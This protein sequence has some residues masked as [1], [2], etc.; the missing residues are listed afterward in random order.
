MPCA[1]STS[2]DHAVSHV[3][4]QVIGS[5]FGACIGI[6]INI[7]GRAAAGQVPVNR[8]QRHGSE[9]LQRQDMTVICFKH[10]I[11]RFRHGACIPL[12]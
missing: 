3:L 2:C 5:V 10:D 4:Q 1:A 8:M 6:Q 12:A 9:H 7:S 11:L